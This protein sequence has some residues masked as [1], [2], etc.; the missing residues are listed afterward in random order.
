M[1]SG[2]WTL[3]DVLNLTWAQLTICIKCVVAVKTEQMTLV[4]D[5]VSMALGG[6]PSKKPSRKK[7]TSAPNKE[8][9]MLNK[10]T[11]MGV[12]MVTESSPGSGQ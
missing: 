11:S 10:L 8:R 9:D 6:K 12:P 3:D 4:M 7:S 5:A 2:G 1:F